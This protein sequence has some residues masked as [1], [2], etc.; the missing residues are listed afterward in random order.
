MIVNW[1][2]IYF[3]CLIRTIKAAP[4]SIVI[5]NMANQGNYI[6]GETALKQSEQFCTDGNWEQALEVLVLALKNRRNTGNNTML[7]R[8]MVR[9]IDLISE[10]ILVSTNICHFQTS[11]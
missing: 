5:I 9:L 6:T 3:L 8:L 4:L 10:S 1:V 11:N 7:E 2:E